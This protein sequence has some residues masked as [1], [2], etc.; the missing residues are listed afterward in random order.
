MSFSH[1]E[2][3]PAHPKKLTVFGFFPSIFG[4]LVSRP[5]FRDIFGRVIVEVLFATRATQFDFLALIHKNVWL[6]HF[7]QLV[8]GHGARRQQ[9]RFGFGGSHRIRIARQAGKG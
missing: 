2:Y 9:I 5:D 7:T 8:A 6:A 1:A 4:F 3:R